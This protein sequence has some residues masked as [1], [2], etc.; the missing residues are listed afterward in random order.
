MGHT[1]K[2]FFLVEIEMLEKN[3]KVLIMG[4]FELHSMVEIHKTS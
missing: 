2:S 4:K 1:K 3:D